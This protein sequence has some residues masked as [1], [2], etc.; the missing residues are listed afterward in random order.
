MFNISI[1]KMNPA[2]PEII[3]S[4]PSQF[5]TENDL[6]TIA[7]KSIPLNAKDGEFS[8]FL[9]KEELV[10]ASYI[11]TIQEQEGKRPDLFSICGAISS[12]EL[13][14]HHF[15]KI[16]E[17]IIQQLKEFRELNS[18]TLVAL[19]S[20][21]YSTLNDGKTEIKITKT[22]TLKIEISKDNLKKI[23]N[24]HTKRINGTKSMW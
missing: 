8:T 22:T 6:K 9:F 21:I 23:K 10:I 3:A 12:D 18:K 17:S 19:I 13:N 14:P 15:K 4:H 20:R 7:L 24:S 16:F 1:N 2:G 11:F 5:F